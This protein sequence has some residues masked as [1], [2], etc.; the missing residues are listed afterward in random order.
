MSAACP[1]ESLHQRLPRGQW[2]VWKSA[3]VPLV[4][5]GMR[6]LHATGCACCTVSLAAQRCL[7][8]GLG[9]FP[10]ASS[11][12]GCFARPVA[13]SRLLMVVVA[14]GARRAV[15]HGGNALASRAF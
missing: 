8:A 1:L 15:M 6:T 11:A 3:K 4:L 2:S 9:G 12:T 10:A 14:Q 5:H 13:R 7:L